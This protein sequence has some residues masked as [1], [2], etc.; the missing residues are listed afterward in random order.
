MSHSCLP[1][2]SLWIANAEVI[3]PS[4][5]ADCPIRLCSLPSILSQ[6]WNSY[7]HLFSLH[8][9]PL[10]R[11]F[12]TV[13]QKDDGGRIN[14]P[15]SV[16]GSE[17]R[18]SWFETLSTFANNNFL[19]L[20]KLNTYCFLFPFNWNYIYSVSLSYFCSSI[21]YVALVTGVAVGVAN[22]SLGCLADRYYLSKFSTFGIFVIS[23]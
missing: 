15:T 10:I 21:Q 14:E 1:L 9:M 19:P 6:C 8:V 12:I 4:E 7:I 18:V 16:S 2:L 11:D 17:K 20:G 23:G 5:P 13:I 22:P 3:V